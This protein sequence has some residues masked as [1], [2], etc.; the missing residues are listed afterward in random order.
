ML[1]VARSAVWLPELREPL[2]QWLEAV[3]AR[4]GADPPMLL[5]AVV[6][7]VSATGYQTEDE[8]RLDVV[9]L[10]RLARQVDLPGFDGVIAA[11]VAH[12]DLFPQVPERDDPGS[13]QR[14]WVAATVAEPIL[15]AY[16]DEV[17]E[18]RFDRP[19]FDAVFDRIE[20]ELAS[21]ATPYTAYAAIDQ[22]DLPDGELELLP[23]VRI[24]AR[25]DSDLETW[26]NSRAGLSAGWIDFIGVNAVLERPYLEKAGEVR[27]ARDS[28]DLVDRLATAIQ[29]QTDSDALAA[30][31]RFRR[32]AT[33]HSGMGGTVTAPPHHGTRRGAL[34]REDVPAVV[35]LYGSLGSSP[36]RAA[37]DLALGRWRSVTVGG[38]PQN[39][40]VD[41][42][43][44]L[45]SLL[46]R[47]ASAT[48]EIRY[49][50]SLRLAALIGRDATDR[51]S[52][53]LEARST[54]DAR[55]KVLHGA[56]TRRLDLPSLAASS[57]DHLRRALIA[58]LTAPTAFDPN[59]I[60]SALL[61]SDLP[62]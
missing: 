57:R 51:R 8:L 49:R 42:W 25:S 54:Y 53:L 43:V 61:S 10:G 23:G 12:R 11:S 24:R 50:A 1:R 20:R 19:T 59:S 34:R 32:D 58:V 41:C 4:F 17:G 2:A 6:R 22:L 3:C 45:E 40:L 14:D 16:I 31:V 62:Q 27:G 26:I 37:C 15:A 55:S 7:E 60:E 30:F 38:P 36:N 47:E 46:F 56:D 44:G 21:P 9:T 52:I 39:T 48:T 5:R 35:R 13:R 28:Q 33:F 18:L 29:L